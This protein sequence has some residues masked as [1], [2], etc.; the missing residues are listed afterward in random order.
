MPRAAINTRPATERSALLLAGDGGGEFICSVCSRRYRSRCTLMSHAKLHEGLTMCSVCG[1]VNVS[2]P[3]LRKHM[4]F[5]HRM[6]WEQI[7]K[8]VPDRRRRAQ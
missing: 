1:K 4:A 7:K 2:I 3:D 6:T 8:L 5:V